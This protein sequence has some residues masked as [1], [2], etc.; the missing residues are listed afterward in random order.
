MCIDVSKRF[1]VGTKMFNFQ[2]SFHLQ[3]IR[4]NARVFSESGFCL[5]FPVKGKIMHVVLMCFTATEMV[6]VC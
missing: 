3:I 4:N 2:L 5:L 6:T 1:F